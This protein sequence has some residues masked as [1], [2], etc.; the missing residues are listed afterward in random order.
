MIA[1]PVVAGVAEGLGL[2]EQRESLGARQARIL[3]VVRTPEEYRRL[4]DARR[5]LAA[6]LGSAHERLFFAAS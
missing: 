1:S 6:A 4:E 5:E 3:G 2:N